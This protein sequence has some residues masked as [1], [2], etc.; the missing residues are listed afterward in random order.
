MSRDTDFPPN[1]LTVVHGRSEWVCE[2]CGKARASEHHHRRARGMG[3][4]RRESTSEASNCLH[5]CRNCHRVAEM[6]RDLAKTL[7]W[8]VDQYSDPASTPVVYR[9]FPVLLDDLGNMAVAA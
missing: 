8:L 5:A 6:N 2:M 9:G 7:G 1:V 4:T 3:G